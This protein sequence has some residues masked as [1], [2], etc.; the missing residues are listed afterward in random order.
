MAEVW[1]DRFGVSDGRTVFI[2]LTVRFGM[3]ATAGNVAPRLNPA[4]RGTE[5]NVR[6]GLLAETGVRSPDSSIPAEQQGTDRR[7]PCRLLSQHRVREARTSEAY[8]RA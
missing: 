8:P 4:V 3:L 5:I 1:R 7:E 6:P 2:L